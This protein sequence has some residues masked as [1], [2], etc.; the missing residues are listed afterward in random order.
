MTVL[1]DKELLKSLDRKID[2][3]GRSNEKLKKIFESLKEIL[4][5]LIAISK[6]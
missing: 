3:I 5:P 4:S 6:V 2:E 1:G